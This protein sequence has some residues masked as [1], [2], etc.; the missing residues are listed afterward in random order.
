MADV[1]FFFDPSCPWTW[2][3][4]RWL[5]TVADARGVEIEWRPFSL[6]VLNDG[7]PD[8]KYRVAVEASHRALRLVERLYQAGRQADIARLYLAIGDL[9]HEGGAAVDDDLVAHAVRSAGLESEASALDD[10]ALDAA[11]E[12]STKAAIASAGPDV[13][14]PVLI[15]AGAERGL[16]GPVLGA[17][18]DKRGSLALWTAVE[19]LAPVNDFFEIKRGRR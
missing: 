1:T 7:K 17:V 4:S 15:L 10:H 8:E 3:A 14:S 9:A 2:R 6:L 11:V 13:G 12:A 5:T 16:H 18:P 19:A